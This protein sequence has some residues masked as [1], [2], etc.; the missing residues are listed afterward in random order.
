MARFTSPRL[1]GEGAAR[2][3]CLAPAA[4]L[5]NPRD[6]RDFLQNPA[7]GPAERWQ[8]GRM[9]RTRNAAYGQPYRGF[10]S[11]PL[12]QITMELSRPYAAYAPPR[13]QPKLLSWGPRR[14]VRPRDGSAALTASPWQ[15]PIPGRDGGILNE[16]I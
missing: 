12:R 11:L 6:P 14:E 9:H 1:R 3:P 13:Q 2:P 8:S 15:Q 5:H 10:E 4:S 16:S 7:L